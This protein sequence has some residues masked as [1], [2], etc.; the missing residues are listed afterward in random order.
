LAVEAAVQA[1]GV[2]AAVQVEASGQLR[3]QASA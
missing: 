2:A 1:L 3:L